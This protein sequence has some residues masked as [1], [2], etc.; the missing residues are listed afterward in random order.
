MMQLKMAGA[1]T[2]YEAGVIR[3]LENTFTKS[4]LTEITLRNVLDNSK[5]FVSAEFISKSSVIM[6]QSIID[7]IATGKYPSQVVKELRDVF[8]FEERHLTTIVNTGFSQYSNA[9]TNLMSADYPDTQKYAYIAF[10][11]ASK[12]SI[13]NRFGD[14]NNEIWN[15]RHKWEP[16]SD[17]LEAQGFEGSVND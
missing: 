12:K 13:L 6:R 9:I 7:G 4:F 2:L 16:I 10:G 11:P 3:V 8:R 5:R 15:C 17:D 14:L 1:F